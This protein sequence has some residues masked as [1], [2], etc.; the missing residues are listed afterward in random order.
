MVTTLGIGMN[1]QHKQSNP[2]KNKRIAFINVIAFAIASHLNNLLSA[3]MIYHD[4]CSD[5]KYPF[6]N[7]SLAC[8]S[9]SLAQK[10]IKFVNNF[11]HLISSCTF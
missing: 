3:V 4:T 9:H 1:C 8:Y 5:M 7:D 2:L 11:D 10:F 6:V